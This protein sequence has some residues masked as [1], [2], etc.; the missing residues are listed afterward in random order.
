[1]VNNLTGFGGG[2]GGPIRVINATNTRWT[3][4]LTS[5]TFN[6]GVASPG[7]LVFVCVGTNNAT[8][9]L[10]PSGY[11]EMEDAAA[12][13]RHLAFAYKVFA[14]GDSLSPSVTLNVAAQGCALM[15]T[16][17]GFD[18]LS[19]PEKGT[20]VTGSSTTPNPP[21]VAPS[22]GASADS[23]VIA[24][25]IGTVSSFA[26]TP[27][28]GYTNAVGNFTDATPT[29]GGVDMASIRVTAASE[30]PGVFTFPVSGAWRTNTVAIRGL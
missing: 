15:Y 13:S 8:S 6:I 16:I 23:L 26:V 7:D 24:M 17:A 11:T 22:W 5:Q 1:M 18:S 10:W 9:L 28:S 2:Y 3:S 21:S 29:V 25:A 4:A 27:P 14:S 30:D 20:V 19:A 12:S